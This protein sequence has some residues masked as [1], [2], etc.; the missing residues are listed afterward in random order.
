MA[1]MP[2]ESRIDFEDLVSGRGLAWTG[3][4]AVL[5]G[6][7][8]F[9]S[10]AFSRDWIGPAQRVIIG[11][12]AAEI[13][14]VAGAALFHRREAAL[15]HVLV[16]AGL[17]VLSLSLMAA[18]RLYELIPIELGLLAAFVTA[19]FTAIIAVRENLQIVA[20]YAVVSALAAPLVLDAPANGVTIAFLAV[21]LLGVTI[22]SL[23]RFW[24]WLPPLAFVL[25]VPQFSIWAAAD[26]STANNSLPV[27]MLRLWGFWLLNAVAAAGEHIRLPNRQIRPGST[28]LLIANAI[29]LAIIGTWVIDDRSAGGLG[30]FVAGIAFA[31]LLLGGYFLWRDGSKHDF[32][33]ITVAIGL[34]ALTI[35]VPVQFDSGWVVVGWALLMTAAALV[36]SRTR[37]EVVG[38]WS[39]IFGGLAIAH[40]VTFEYPISSI[41]TVASSGSPFLNSHSLVTG[42]LMLMLLA[43]VRC[44]NLAAA[45][46]LAIGIC[47][48]LLAY[49]M[50]FELS[51]GG[52]VAGW[53]ALAI[54][55]ICLQR[56]NRFSE[57]V[58]AEDVALS[59]F[60]V[61][62][63]ERVVLPLVQIAG[64]V[65]ATIHLIAIE[66]PL[67][68]VET[69]ERSGIPFMN[70]DGLILACVI[71]SLAIGAYYSGRGK[72]RR[73]VIALCGA[74]IL[75]AMPF[76]VAN[77]SLVCG[78]SAV[79]LLFAVLQLWPA[80]DI[81]DVSWTQD[82]NAMPNLA[83]D[84]S[85]YSLLVVQLT[86]WGL[87]AVY[88]GLSMLPFDTMSDIR[89]SNI[90]F[91]NSGTL[92]TG[93]LTAAALGSWQL[94]RQR[95][96]RNRWF[97]VATAVAVYLIPFE[98]DPA[99]TVV[100]W[101]A[102][103]VVP[104]VLT[105]RDGGSERFYQV[106][107]WTIMGMAL[108]LCLTIV[109]TPNRLMVDHFS[110]VDHP[111]FLSW[112]T[113]T[114]LTMAAIL[115]A[116]ARL[117]G[118]YRFS[119]RI[120]IGAAALVVYALSIGIV[121]IFQV[122]VDGVNDI[123]ELQKQSQVAL[124]ILWAGLGVGAFVIGIVRGQSLIRIGGLILLGLATAKVFIYDLAA[125]DASYRVL[126]FIGLGVL[127]L[128]S[129]YVYQRA[130]HPENENGGTPSPA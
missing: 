46:A 101:A 43:S 65:L 111:P 72:G 62:A 116:H 78:W 120:W 124:S 6:A 24:D 128:A 91:L 74:L 59:G 8:F 122:K 27:I 96:T 52:L 44:L 88:F 119:P 66:Y 89:D 36:Y 39:A 121:D 35:T 16:A 55:F 75:L 71:F 45:R 98:V 130:V 85:Q 11:C 17:G 92:A 125:L 84:V 22:K 20:A 118:S 115:V 110:A 7:V 99:L 69:A 104:L 41:D 21:A 51:G 54:L 129:S 14:I 56:S 26:S 9:L 97:A 60:S 77:A 33:L 29:V 31:H 76:E 13:M 64:L 37:V 93:F 107:E 30:L 103:A 28:L 123:A 87:G 40:V 25:T 5:I 81:D 23:Y 113:A 48:G 63:L 108:T 90:A 49:A 106:I 112:A 57:N 4:L 94:A 12:V 100:M 102:L 126:S 68:E 58:V 3:G 18:T 2:A 70:Q 95:N 67:S 105:Q 34:I 53:S 86:G 47:G 42:F 117:F 15:G 61:S 50:P 82:Q 83:V 114:L 19:V 127:L 10:L 80:L 32:G 73:F 38:G 79:A 1:K 109:A